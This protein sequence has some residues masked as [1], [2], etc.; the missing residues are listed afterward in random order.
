MARR[1]RDDA[2]PGRGDLDRDF[3]DLCESQL[4]LP[5]GAQPFEPARKP[6]ALDGL[7]AQIRLQHREEALERRDGH[8]RLP[9]SLQRRVAAPDAANRPPAAL[10]VQRQR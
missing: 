2:R 4:G 8:R 6:V 3:A 7:T 9:D 10:D 1:R 5:F